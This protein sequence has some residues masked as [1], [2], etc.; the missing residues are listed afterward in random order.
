MSS[1]AL[2]ALSPLDGRY[3][4]KVEPLRPIFSEFGLMH[5][6]VHV[7]IEW[8][9][10]LAADAQ[11]IELPA[12][13]AAQI[14]TLKAI[15]TDFSVDDGAR[16]KAI[17]ATTNHDVKA[18]EYFIKEKLGAD[19]SLKQALEFVHFA[20]TSEDINNLSYALMLRDAREQ[21]LL[22]MFDGVITQLRELSHANA[23]LPILSRTHGQTASPSTLGKEIANVVARLQRQRKQLA[24]VE[25]SGKINGAVGNYNAHAITYPEVDWQQFS[26]RFIE[27]LGL[28]VNAYTTQIEPHDG[29]AEYCDAVRR[30]NIILIDLARDIWGYISLGYFKQTLKAGEVGSSTMPHKV[31]PI[32]FENAEGN[33]GLANALLGHFAEKLP[34]SRWQRDLTD[35]T[36]L[37]ALGTAFGHTLIALESLKKGL[38]KLTVNADR[39]AADLDASWE[40]LAEAVQTVMRRYG[41]PEPYEQLKALTRGQGIT[42]ESMHTFISGLDL[43]AEAKQRLLALTPGSYI[44]LADE[45]AKAI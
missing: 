19:A 41:L 21:V 29:V 24:A 45:L 44:G 37:R 27:S 12:F 43:P 15:A 30:A 35:S 1:H 13:T 9:L 5:R 20:C 28:E 33:F 22:P 7:E 25:I 10:A 14:K 8:L 32:D 11:I 16:I 4:S 23:A 38:G 34:I 36:V 2:T 42:R 3:A 6:R 39:L 40:V 18:V 31:N 17:E 26:Q